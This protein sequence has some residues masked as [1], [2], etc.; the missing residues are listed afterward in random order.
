MFVLSVTRASAEADRKF[1]LLWGKKPSVGPGGQGSSTLIPPS[2]NQV[3][4]QNFIYENLFKE[5]LIE[6]RYCAFQR[7]F[8]ISVRNRIC[9]MY[10]Q[11]QAQPT[12]YMR[13]GN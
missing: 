3:S 12:I 7:D 1:L 9:G 2:P 5:D 10:V 4:F 8:W 13:T 11:T 6:L